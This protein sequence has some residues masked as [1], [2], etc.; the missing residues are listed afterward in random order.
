MAKKRGKG[1]Q[2]VLESYKLLAATPG[3]RF[4]GNIES[5]E[6][7]AGAADVVVTDGFTGNIFVKTA[8]A[9]AQLL[10]QVMKE[11]LMRGTISTVGAFLARHALQRVRRRM[12][13]TEFGGALLLG[14]QGLVVVAHGRSNANAIRHAIRVAKEG[15][16]QNILEKIGTEIQSTI[17]SQL[18][19]TNG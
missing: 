3:L 2:L 13:D 17:H 11:E 9:T 16:E 18:V 4:L 19:T 7:V 1:N 10:L 12:D 6:V 15:I 8:E 5:K 14:L